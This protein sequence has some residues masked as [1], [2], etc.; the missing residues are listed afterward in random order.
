[1]YK[2]TQGQTKLRMNE[3]NTENADVNKLRKRNTFTQLMRD[4]SME[5]CR[6]TTL[7]GLQYVGE[8][9]RSFLERLF[10]LTTFLIS[11][12]VVIYYII[13]VWIKWHNHP[14]LVSFA[15]V[16]T[17][18]WHIPFPAITICSQI[19]VRQSV[20]NYTKAVLKDNLTDEETEKM[21]YAQ[22]FCNNDYFIT[23]V[24]SNV[25][26]TDNKAVEFI[27]QAAPG[28][29]D[30][31]PF[32]KWSGTEEECSNIFTPVLTDDGLCYTFNML[33][34]EQ[35]FKNG[36]IQRQGKQS[37]NTRTSD[38]NLES[39]YHDIDA[40]D[41]FPRRS[42]GTGIRTGLFLLL[43]SENEDEDTMCS[44]PIDGVKV[45]LHNPTDYPLVQSDYFHVPLQRDV[46][47]SI[48]PR[49]ITTSEGLKNY[50]PQRRWCYFSSERHLRHFSIYTQH[51]CDLECLT[52]YTLTQCGCVAYYM[53]R[54]KDTPICAVGQR[55]CLTNASDAFAMD[56]DGMLECA[57]LPACSEI[58]YDVET[59]QSTFRWAEVL[60][61]VNAWKGTNIS[62]D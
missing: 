55:G 49:V 61:A 21:E 31:I 4:N 20:F 41:A 12:G 32:C 37:N 14:V 34:F 17:P 30:V 44:T 13:R 42:V 27:E 24:S 29:F 10:W 60:K 3:F 7:H 58:T 2:E 52:N 50:D 28:L 35:M 26:T 6:S 62:I 38:W 1:M 45:L 25:A 39:G 11:T 51:N 36:T 9:H 40:K 54:D 8:K 53:P 47:V 56:D 48:K 46:V 15:E 59:S 22:L 19:K 16:A 43:S 18:I 57:C 33:S 23:A 5:F